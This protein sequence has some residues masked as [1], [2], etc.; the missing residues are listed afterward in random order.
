M[1]T[2]N[3][4]II[5]LILESSLVLIGLLMKWDVWVGVVCYWFILLLKNLNDYL[6]IR[7]SERN[8]GR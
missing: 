7:K 2:K 3:I 8:E 1:K 5:L 6:E 4:M